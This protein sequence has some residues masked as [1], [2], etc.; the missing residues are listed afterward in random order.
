VRVR[1]E[2]VF[3]AMTQKGG[4]TVRSIAIERMKVCSTMK[5]SSYDL[6]RLEALIRLRRIPIDGIGVPA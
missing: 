6:K 1:G 4:M 3:A 2:H 5:A